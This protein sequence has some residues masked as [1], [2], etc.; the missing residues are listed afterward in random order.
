MTQWVKLYEDINHDPRL[1]SV[2]LSAQAVYFRLLPLVK[3]GGGSLVAVPSKTLT[4]TV[5]VAL[6][7]PRDVVSELLGELAAVE[8]IRIAD[9]QLY[10]LGHRELWSS[11]NDDET[12]WALARRAHAGWI[13]QRDG[14]RCVY[15]GLSA[16]LTLDHVIP[17]SRGGS[18]EPE[19]LVTACRPCNSSKGARTPEEWRVS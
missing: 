10:A 6:H 1:L 5:A 17:K 3:R 19:N 11:I 2:G 8:L 14:N 7:Q 13:F 15:C 16:D 18:H 9:G 4:D 12:E